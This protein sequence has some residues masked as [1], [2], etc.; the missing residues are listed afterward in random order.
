MQYERLFGK[1]G[2]KPISRVAFSS[3]RESSKTAAPTFL[4]INKIAVILGRA[5]NLAELGFSYGLVRLQPRW[6]DHDE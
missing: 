1:I 2:R 5:E 4:S 3:W 6:S